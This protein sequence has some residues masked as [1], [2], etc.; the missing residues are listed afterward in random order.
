MRHL[1]G[2][3]ASFTLALLSTVALGQESAQPSPFGVTWGAGFDETI[4]ALPN[5]KTFG[6]SR[7]LARFDPSGS[8]ADAELGAVT[9]SA[10]GRLFEMQILGKSV[11]N[12][13]YGTVT[14][15]RLGELRESLTD[16]YGAPTDRTHVAQGYSG[17]YF[18]LGLKTGMSR[19]GYIWK[20]SGVEI[21][22][23]IAA[24]SSDTLNW[25]LIYTNLAEQSEADAAS[26]AREKD[27]L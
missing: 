11:E 7:S 13:P 9:F 4:K 10:R 20:V 18:G 1:L 24:D 16:K 5:A 21:T 6:E 15:G 3:R 12:D 27:A 23:L 14:V 25:V 2:I 19:Y 8:I 22:L 26:A 17:Q